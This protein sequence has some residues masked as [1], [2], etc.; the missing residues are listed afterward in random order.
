MS[1][2]GTAEEI[3]PITAQEEKE[4]HRT[5]FLLCDYQQKTK[6]KE[7]MRDLNIF[8]QEKTEQ[9][10]DH[11][12]NKEKNNTIITE[13]QLR[14]EELTREL[15]EI[16]NKMDK[17]ITCNDVVEMFKFLKFKISRKEVEELI[18]EVDENL[19]ECIDFAEFRLMFNR[20]IID[21]TGL[22]PSRMFWLTQFLIYDS[23]MNGFVSVDETMNL[24]YA[25]YG[26]NKL[27]SKL[28]D[29]FG[30]NMNETGRQG[31][32]ISYANFVKAVETT[33]MKTFLST[34]KGRIAASKGFGKTSKNMNN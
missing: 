1:S 13:A 20:N 10:N 6:I 7:E 14:L 30:P 18:W 2:E 3:V 15:Q 9:I 27:D 34:T 12:N 33:Q 28:K 17:K 21:R 19:D 29:I 4:M 5:F 11:N 26:G 31:G 22:E 8:I 16:E 23:N 24:L 32:E 25:R